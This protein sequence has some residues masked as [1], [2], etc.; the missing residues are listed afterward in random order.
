MKNNVKLEKKLSILLVSY[1]LG[2]PDCNINFLQSF[3]LG[4]MSRCKKSIKV[5]CVK[6]MEI[7]IGKND[8]KDK[9]KKRKS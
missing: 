1:Y 8:G 9:R 5:K 2:T 7:Q 3:Y 4:I 6:N